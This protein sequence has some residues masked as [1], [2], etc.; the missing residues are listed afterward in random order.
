MAAK[1]VEA[2]PG[3]SLPAALL[4]EVAE[5]ARAGRLVVFPT[6]TV[7]GVGSSALVTGVFERIY[8]AKA[9]DPRKPLPILVPS[10]EEARRWA[11]F[12]RGAEA[13]AKRFWPGA[14]TLVLPPTPEGRALLSGGARSLALRVPNHPGMLALLEASGVPWA[15]TSANLSGEPAAADGAAA[16]R[17]LGDAADYVVDAG[18]AGGR[19]STVVDLSGPEPR[20]LREGALPAA[21][22]L[23]AL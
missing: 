21:T 7:Y 23:Q 19:E 2:F 5:A 11:A 20:V 4:T 15:T 6:D 13:L 16:A 17:T 22:I 12:G 10:L 14:L 8:A 9:R 1:V 18:P 3:G